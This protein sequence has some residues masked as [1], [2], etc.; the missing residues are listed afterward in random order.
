MD[1]QLYSLGNGIRV[2]HKP[3]P[4]SNLTHACVLIH[5]GSRDEDREKSGLAHFLEHMLFKGTKKRSSYHILNRMEMVGAELNAYTTKE[6]TCL[7]ASFLNQ[8]TDRALELF[9]DI[10]LQSTFPSKEINKEKQVVMDEIDSYLDL[11]EESIQDEFENVLF[12]GHVLGDNILGSKES[13]AAIKQKD[14]KDFV[15]DHYHPENIIIGVYGEMDEQSLLSMV[16]NHFPLRAGKTA[17]NRNAPGKYKPE[18]RIIKKNIVQAHAIIGNRAGSIHHKQK[19]AMLLL[20]NYLGGPGMSSRLNLVIREKK[21]ICYTIDANYTPWSD[22]G[23]FSIYMGTDQEKIEKC[24]QLVLKEMRRVAEQKLSTTALHQ[25][26]KKL[27]GQISLA[28]ENHLSVII[29]LCKSILDHGK[30]DSLPEIFMKIEKITAEQIQD[31]ANLLFA[32]NKISTAI[33][34]PE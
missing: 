7:H 19:N 3:N 33:Y 26:K 10:M 13:V 25:A 32:Q 20:S 27:I 22:T 11:P 8:Y 4:N 29:S 21:G 1:Y 6:Y 12:K 5:C 2:V 16:M 31:A 28:E 15:K 34:L 23:I 30:A 18:H 9:S 24:L 14:L 17:N